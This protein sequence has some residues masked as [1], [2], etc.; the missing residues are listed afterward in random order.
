MIVVV[1]YGLGNITSVCRAFEKVG[2]DVMVVSDPEDIIGARKIVL[3]GVGAFKK[4]MDNIRNLELLDCLK[5]Y[6]NSGCAY[7][8]ICLG[9]QVLF[10]VSH[11]HGI[12]SGFGAIS[13]SVEMFCEGVRIPHIGWNQVEISV[14]DDIFCGIDNNS[15]FY[16]DHSYRVGVCEEG[17]VRGRTEYGT[18]FVSAVRKANIWG[19]QF[20]PEKS[21]S[22]GLKMIKNFV[23]YVC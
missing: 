7:L 2:A 5:E 12:N 3:P 17:A 22:V 1:D 19:V 16:F 8:G 15:Y 13:G 4:A 23:D 9:M 6:Y 18:S 11:E 10:E 20:H 21:G 14:P